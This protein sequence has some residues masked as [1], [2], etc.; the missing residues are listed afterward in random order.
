MYMK[1]WDKNIYKYSAVVL[2]L[3]HFFFQVTKFSDALKSYE[4]IRVNNFP[5]AAKDLSPDLQRSLSARAKTLLHFHDI[6]V[7]NSP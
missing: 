5:H 6:S 1:R 4:Y 2:S 7:V 3:T